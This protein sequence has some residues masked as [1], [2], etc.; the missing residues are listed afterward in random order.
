MK[1][2]IITI[3]L[4][5]SSFALAQTITIGENLATNAAT[6]N[7][8]YVLLQFTTGLKKGI[9]LPAVDSKDT[10]VSGTVPGTF[11]FD[12]S[13]NK[14][15]LAVSSSVD[16]PTVSDWLDFTA[17]PTTSPAVNI[18]KETLTEKTTAKAIIGKDTSS[19]EGVL[20]L[21]P[22]DPNVLPQTLLLPVVDKFDDIADPSPGMM[23]YIKGTG[24]ANADAKK[25]LAV[26]NGTY[27]TFWKPKNP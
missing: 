7:N 3:S 2:Y 18:Y 15:K 19:A 27:W 17:N 22:K 26:F 9:I 4:M 5:V 25:R 24:T 6:T 14:V 11:I 21:E 20:V 16:T 13:D 10:M 12:T 23:V 8:P 1:K